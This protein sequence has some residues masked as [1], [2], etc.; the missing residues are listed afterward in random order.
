MSIISEGKTVHVNEHLLV[1]LK[2]ITDTTERANMLKAI[3]K[4]VQTLI[5]LRIFELVP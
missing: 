1:D 2:P 4:E 5:D 3:V